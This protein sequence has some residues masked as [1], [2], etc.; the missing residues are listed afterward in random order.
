MGRRTGAWLGW[1]AAALILYFFE[2]NTG[3]RA[4]L[5][6][7]L[8][9]PLLSM[10]CAR[11][12]ARRQ[13]VFLQAPET[14]AAGEKIRCTIR[15][16]QPPWSIGCRTV[17]VMNG[18]NGLT[19]EQFEAE[20]PV[21]Y[22]GTCEQAVE[23]GRCGRLSLS[24]SR[25]E[26]R[27]WFGLACFARDVRAE[28]SIF[29]KPALYPVSVHT[30]PDAGAASREAGGDHRRS[31][32]PEPGDLRPYVPGD[33][34]R[35]I[36]WKLSEKTDQILIRESSPEA[37]SRTALLLETSFP[38]QADPEAMHATARGLLSVSRALA[39]EG[40]A[41]AVVTADR[42]EAVIAEVTDGES[43]RRAEEQVLAAECATGADSIGTMLKQQ[44]PDLRFRR[45]ILFTPHP[46]TDV[47]SPAECQPV[48]LVLPPFVPCTSPGSGI[49]VT[50]MDPADAGIDL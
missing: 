46:E 48:T 21:P 15:L 50:S 29:L 41:H 28:R 11:M 27:D 33:P 13:E 6:I 47:F 12:S 8:L 20:V 37:L 10:A 19:G 3:T 36:H 44:Y 39:A 18:R 43:F 26:T 49:R 16:R 38:E 34:V 5:V 9:V 40:I 24:V 14:A 30:D 25:V 23:S 17:C 31:E 32:D 4:V 7:S 1:L 35:K 45:A 22:G 2:N 42:G